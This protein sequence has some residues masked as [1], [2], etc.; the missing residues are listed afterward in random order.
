LFLV[1]KSLIPVY[2]LLWPQDVQPLLISMVGKF[3]GGARNHVGALDQR[4]IGS[5]LAVK[6]R[7]TGACQVMRRPLIWSLWLLSVSIASAT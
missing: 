6:C 3:D 1:I 5:N 4:A 2:R 7:S